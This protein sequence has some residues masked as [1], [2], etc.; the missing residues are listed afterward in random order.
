MADESKI[1]QRIELE[2]E[3]EYNA[4]LAEARRNLKTLRSELKAETAELG[5]NATAQQKN[6][7]RT[8]SLQK[9]IKEQEKVVRT[10]QDALKEV[11]EKYGD[12]E[13]AVAKWEQKLNDARATLANMKNSLD[14][15]GNGMK[16]IQSGAEMGVVASNNFADSL[17]KIADVGGS[18]SSAIEGA[19]STVVGHI[20]DAISELWS[21]LMDV[22]ARANNWTDIATMWNSSAGNIQ[23]WYHAVG[24]EAKDFSRLTNYVTKIVTGDQK[25]IAESASVSAEAYTDQ[26]EYAMAVMDSLSHMDTKKQIEALT[27]MGI[28]GAK[29]EGWLDMLKAWGD[30]Q[31]NAEKFDA[32]KGGLGLTDEELEKANQLAIDVATLQQSWQALKDHALVNLFG[33]VALNVTGNLQQIVEAF[34]EY[35]KATDDAGRDAAL[36][37][38]KDNIIQIFTNIKDAIAQ[39]I[40]LLDEL[41]KELQNSDDATAKALGDIL[42]KIVNA[43]SW[44]MVEDNWQTVVKGFE[45]LIGVWAAG[46]VVSAVGNLASFAANILTVKNGGKWIFGGASGFGA[47]AGAGATTLTQSAVTS[48]IMSASGSIASAIAGLTMSVGVV[49]LAAPVVSALLDVAKGNWPDW[50]PNPNKTTGETLL[51]EASKETQ[52]AVT[53]ALET[54]VNLFKAPSGKDLLSGLRNWGKTTAEETADEAV[55]KATSYNMPAYTERTPQGVVRGFDVTQDQIDAVEAFWDVWRSGDTE[56]FDSAYEAFV[57]AFVGNEDAFK[58]LDQMLDELYNYYVV[59]G[60][61][62]SGVE[63]LPADWWRNGGGSLTS[64]DI[65]GFRSVPGLMKAAVREGVSGIKVSLDGYAVGSIVAPYVSEMIARDMA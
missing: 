7:V 13:E 14:D 35:F 34:D 65:S 61:N 30:I 45:A 2:G 1:K 17:K 11:K 46:K 52:D 63:D 56:D 44:F 36:Q 38:I 20:T 27:G 59:N 32:Q 22:S 6:E 49:T 18:V 41:A 55:K 40:G 39:G 9:Q 3:K 21:Q 12:N 64:E 50:L 58:R 24:A 60:I 29:Q 43:L 4:A 5:N 48:A 28:S 62:P 37:K 42:E 31:K 10:Y 19:F 33:D 16:N 51:P 8:K 54:P 47:G 15:V 23:K 57:N 26:W 25:K 53:N